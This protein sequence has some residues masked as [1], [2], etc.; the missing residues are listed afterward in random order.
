LADN[1][2]YN[3]KNVIQSKIYKWNSSQLA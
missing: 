3:N 1:I 2:T